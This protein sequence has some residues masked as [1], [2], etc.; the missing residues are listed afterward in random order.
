MYSNCV[1]IGN[2]KK[3]KRNHST[4]HTT[5][6]I[7]QTGDKEKKHPI[8]RSVYSV[9]QKAQEE[10]GEVGRKHWSE[11]SN[12]SELYI[13][14]VLAA[15]L[16]HNQ[17]QTAWTQRLGVDQ[18][19]AAYHTAAQRITAAETTNTEEE[20][21]AGPHGQPPLSTGTH[22]NHFWTLIQIFLKL[23]S[24]QWFLSLFYDLK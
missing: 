5:S 15:V 8:R 21:N 12:R 4:G 18:R 17:K 9:S 11:R 19:P 24:W 6:S 16:T 13:C 7:S 23:R 3:E 10:R 1:G 22:Q 14:L 20:R 2:S